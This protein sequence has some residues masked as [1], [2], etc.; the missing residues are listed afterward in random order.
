MTGLLTEGVA[1]YR[2]LRPGFKKP[3][4]GFLHLASKSSPCVTGPIF[5]NVKIFLQWYDII[6]LR[7]ISTIYVR[8][9][10]VD[11]WSRVT[12]PPKLELD[13]AASLPNGDN[14][15]AGGRACG[16]TTSYPSAVFFVI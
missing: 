1:M 11:A 3:E 13:L 7:P 16:L 10:M 6:M 9:S 12:T 8:A 4:R 15:V 5:P 14:V 2:L